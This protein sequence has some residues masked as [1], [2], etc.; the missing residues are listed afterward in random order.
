MPAV[1][2]HQYLE[3]RTETPPEDMF[4]HG[5]VW[6]LRI[7]TVVIFLSMRVFGDEALS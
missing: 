4:G 3:R 1:A 2:C 7:M 5:P 6:Y